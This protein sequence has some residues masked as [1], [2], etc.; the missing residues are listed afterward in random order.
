MTLFHETPLIDLMAVL[1]HALSTDHPLAFSEAVARLTKRIG[2]E[3]TATVVAALVLERQ[4]AAA[5]RREPGAD[6]VVSCA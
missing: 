4:R 3:P 5:A 2:V 6:G 1:E